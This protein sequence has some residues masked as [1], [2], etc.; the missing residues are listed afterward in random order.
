MVERGIPWLQKLWEALKFNVISFMLESGWR[1][2]A[3]NPDAWKDWKQ[4]EKGATE[5]EMVGWHHGLTWWTWIWASSRSWWWTGKPG[6]MQSMG[7]Q[8]VGHDWATELNWTDE[9]YLES[10]NVFM[11]TKCVQKG[12]FVNACSTFFESPHISKLNL[13]LSKV[14]FCFHC[15]LN[16]SFL[17]L[18]SMTLDF[19][20][21]LGYIDRT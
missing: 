8:R 12:L 18:D 1:S 15:P 9:N 20:P 19:F 5:D 2:R 16:C 3:I 4:E 11:A 6:V 7:L 21:A 17:T 14:H 10:T 13:F